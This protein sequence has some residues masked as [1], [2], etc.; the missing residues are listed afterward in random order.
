MVLFQ[1]ASQYLFPDS[2]AKYFHATNLD[3]SK[4]G[5]FKISFMFNLVCSICSG[6]V[7]PN[8]QNRFVCCQLRHTIFYIPSISFYHCCHEVGGSSS[9]TLHNHLP[10]LLF[11]CGHDLIIT[12]DVPCFLVFVKKFLCDS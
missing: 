5:L 8:Y 2:D 9:V 11:W 1:N 7:F 4:M 12:L 3:I 6:C 10:P